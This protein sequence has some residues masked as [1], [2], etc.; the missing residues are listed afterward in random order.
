MTTKYLFFGLN[1]FS[2]FKILKDVKESYMLNRILLFNINLF[3][4][5]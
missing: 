1:I 2:A 5:I 4:S 3:G